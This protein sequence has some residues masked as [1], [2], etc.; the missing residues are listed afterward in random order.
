MTIMHGIRT[1]MIWI[2]LV[3]VKFSLIYGETPE[4]DNA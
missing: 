2:N 3:H 1:S 4:E